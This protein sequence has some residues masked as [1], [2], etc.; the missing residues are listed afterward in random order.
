MTIVTFLPRSARQ[1]LA[2]RAAEMF[3]A[4]PPTLA[5]DDTQAQQWRN[6][7]DFWNGEIAA[8]RNQPEI[9]QV[10]VEL[11]DE[12]RAIRAILETVK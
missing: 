6:A 2:D 7:I 4:G 11:R 8:M 10:L 5:L 3:G 1:R 9:M 12:L